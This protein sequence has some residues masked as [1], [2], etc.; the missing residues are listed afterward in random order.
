MGF[1]DGLEEGKSTGG[2]LRGIFME[3]LKKQCILFGFLK[4]R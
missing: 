2:V 1:K 3:T 4:E